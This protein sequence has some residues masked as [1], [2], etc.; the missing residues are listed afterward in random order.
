MVSE[1]CD[2]DERKRRTSST[3]SVFRIAAARAQSSSRRPGFAR[4]GDDR[5]ELF[6][7]VAAVDA[8]SPAQ[9]ATSRRRTSSAAAARRRRI[10]RAPATS[11]RPGSSRCSQRSSASRTGESGAALAQRGDL[12]R[13]TTG[14]DDELADEPQEIDDEMV[15]ERHLPD[16]L[17]VALVDVG[18]QR[19]GIDLR[20]GYRFADAGAAAS[21]LHFGDVSRRSTITGRSSRPA[22]D[23]YPRLRTGTPS[24]SECSD[25][26]FGHR[27]ASKRWSGPS[28]PSRSS[29]R[30]TRRLLQVQRRPS[31]G[32]SRA[33]PA[34]RVDAPLAP[35]A[36]FV[37]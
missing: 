27:R 10:P 20:V 3:S 28:A 1:I 13:Y 12:S 26:H 11:R 6:A 5:E 32:C 25:A 22:R 18:Q 35:R 23:R 8:R 33:R 19:R 29:C 34:Q 36:H 17:L 2:R 7:G 16:R 24:A 30:P 9:C 21:P 4:S 37:L 31:S 15:L 14:A